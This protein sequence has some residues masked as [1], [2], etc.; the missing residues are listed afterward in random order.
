ML[1]FASAVSKE[2]SYGKRYGCGPTGTPWVALD[3]LSFS[4]CQEQ[5]SGT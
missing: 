1:A 2:S 4:A 3:I 5:L